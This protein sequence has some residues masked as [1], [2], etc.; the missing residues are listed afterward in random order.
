[1]NQF[2]I[3]NNTTFTIGI[4]LIILIILCFLFEIY[5]ALKIFCCK[6]NSETH[7]LNPRNERS[8]EEANVPDL[9]KFESLRQKQC[10]VVYNTVYV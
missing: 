5:L 10:D 9:K 3:N 2:L 7:C 1:M 6:R 4:I 8:A